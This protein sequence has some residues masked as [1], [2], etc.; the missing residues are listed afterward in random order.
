MRLKKVYNTN[1]Q[2]RLLTKLCTALMITRNILS[3]T[4]P[5]YLANVN[6]GNLSK[7]NLSRPYVLFFSPVFFFDLLLCSRVP[8]PV[9]FNKQAYKII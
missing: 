1:L 5:I 7:A 2:H 8:V 4:P 9:N 3:Q 6:K